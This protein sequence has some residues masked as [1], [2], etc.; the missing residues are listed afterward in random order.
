MT[1]DESRDP[2]PDDAASAPPDEEYATERNAREVSP[3]ERLA[4]LR[5]TWGEKSA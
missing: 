3:A 4:K 2:R 5:A 1:D